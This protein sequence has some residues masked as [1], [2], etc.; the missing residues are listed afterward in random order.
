MEGA[1]QIPRT[2]DRTLRQLEPPHPSHVEGPVSPRRLGLETYP[3]PRPSS[4][5]IPGNQR[6][7]TTPNLVGARTPSTCLLLVGNPDR[8]H[9][10][11]KAC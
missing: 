3:N 7:K 2:K 10:P 11:I 5:T 6:I 1:A 9:C 4:L 8:E